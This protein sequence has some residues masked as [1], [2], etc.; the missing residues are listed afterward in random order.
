MRVRRLKALTTS[1]QSSFRPFRTTTGHDPAEMG[2][3][4]RN[5]YAVP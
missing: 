3:R 1:L 5:T 4:I 2:M